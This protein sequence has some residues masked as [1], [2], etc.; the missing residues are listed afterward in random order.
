[1]WNRKTILSN[2]VSDWQNRGLL[3]DQTAQTLFADTEQSTNSF[4]F[5]NILI[6]LAVI[7]LGFAAMTFV[8]ANWE[9]M[10]RLTRVGVIVSAMWIF[11]AG[12]ALFHWRNQSWIA[13]VFTLGACAMFGAGIMLI[14]QIYHIQ[15]S[16]KD[17][18]WLWAIGTLLAAGIT[19]SI[20]SLALTI[21]LFLTWTWLEPNM[22]SWRNQEYQWFFP[23]YMI[24]CAG[25]AYWMQSRFCA[26]LIALASLGWAVPT[27]LSLLADNSASFAVV[28]IGLG[29][30]TMSLMLLSDRAKN[31]LRGFERPLIFY[32]L[33]MIGV[34]LAVWGQHPDISWANLVATDLHMQAIPPAIVA[35]LVTGAMAIFALR[36]NHP[37]TYD[38]VATAAFTTASFTFMIFFGGYDVIFF[39]LLLAGSIWIIRMGWRIEFRPIVVLGFIA[40][41]IV[42]IWVYAETIGSLLGTSIF[43]GGIG[44]L[45]LA[46]V[47]IV[48][49]FTRTKSEGAIK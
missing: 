36:Q 12:S 8:A 39:G 22:F 7:C 1:M 49:R 15:D 2:A 18:V 30:V 46:G 11:W 9:D 20:P 43:Y 28:L 4:S 37:N 48:P 42:M 45:L 40:F 13:Q 21:V 31:L 44:V 47:F 14:S 25:L 33:G 35:V 16:S 3:D 34:L 27:A 41:A 17:D 32:I 19:R 38:I 23:G 5:Q 24:L 10:T 26:H 6:L 29:F